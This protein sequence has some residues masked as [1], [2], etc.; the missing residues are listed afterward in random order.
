[1]MISNQKYSTRVLT[2]L[3]EEETCRTLRQALRKEGL[4]VGEEVDLSGRSKDI[5]VFRFANTPS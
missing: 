3:S 4:E 2:G 5:L 1:M